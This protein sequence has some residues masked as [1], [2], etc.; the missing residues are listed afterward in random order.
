MAW[1]SK[2][3][4]KKAKQVKIKKIKPL[5]TRNSGTFT[6]SAFWS[7]IRSAL[8]QKSRWWKPISECK[9]NSKRKY[10]GSNNRQ[11]FEYKCN[12]CGNYFP[13]KKISVDHIN[14]A[15]SLMRAEDLDGFIGRL[16][17]EIDN[18][19]VACDECHSIKTAKDKEQIKINRQNGNI[20]SGR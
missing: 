12:I 10:H 15:G 7:F 20:Q 11:K 5:K 8:R 3:I 18:L 17:C 6:E 4:V 16:F 19:Q 9:A 1:R 14:P 13:D 2:K